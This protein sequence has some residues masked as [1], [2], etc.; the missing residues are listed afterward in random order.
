MSTGRVPACSEP[1]V[2]LRSA[3]QISPRLTIIEYLHLLI[4][5]RNL[6]YLAQPA[7][8]PHLR[9]RHKETPIQFH[10]MMAWSSPESGISK[11]PG[12]PQSVRAQHHSGYRVAVRSVL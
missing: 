10:S 4:F 3:S 7:L 11:M 2:G 5:G 1:R 8:D 12:I 9:I 6:T